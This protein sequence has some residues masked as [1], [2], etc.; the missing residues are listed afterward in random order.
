[1]VSSKRLLS[2]LVGLTFVGGVLSATPDE[3]KTRSIYQVFTDRFA[4][5]DSS[6]TTDC[7]SQ[8]YGYCGGTWQGI[9]NKLDYIQVS[10]SALRVF[11]REVGTLNLA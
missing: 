3:W 5:T 8:T 10:E 9:I 7:P 6:N 11:E 1:M 2:A 4:R